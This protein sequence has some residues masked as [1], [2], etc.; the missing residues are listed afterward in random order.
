[1]IL[2]VFDYEINKKLN[3]LESCLDFKKN[4]EVSRQKIIEKVKFLKK[5]VNRCA[6]MRLHPKVLRF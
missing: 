2:K 1:M 3:R 4:C 5:L 6:V